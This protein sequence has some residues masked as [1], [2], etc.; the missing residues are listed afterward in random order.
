MD[1][2]AHRS[3]RYRIFPSL[4]GMLA[5]VRAFVLAARRS[6][7][8]QRQGSSQL[9]GEL[10]WKTRPPFELFLTHD[11]PFDRP[12]RRMQNAH[13]QKQGRMG[14]IGRIGPMGGM[15]RMGRMGDDA[16]DA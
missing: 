4:L 3:K 16:S 10:L 2:R 11:P 14:R 7:V 1:A 9:Q 12:K 6:V 5:Q 8:G 15:G 13:G